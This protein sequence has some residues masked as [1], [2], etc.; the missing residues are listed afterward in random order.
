MGLAFCGIAQAAEEWRDA[1]SGERV[2]SQPDPA[3]KPGSEKVQMKS[4]PAGVF[5]TK[6]FLLGAAASRTLETHLAGLKEEELVP[7]FEKCMTQENPATQAL[8]TLKARQFVPDIAR[9]L[10]HQDAE[11]Q[12]TAIWALGEFQAREYAPEIAALMQDRSRLL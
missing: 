3:A 7:F 2:T 5:D 9:A 8:V 10:K 4:S 6:P 11:V 1:K 12:G